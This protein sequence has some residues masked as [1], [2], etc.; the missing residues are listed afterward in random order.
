[1]GMA[2]TGAEP[3][4]WAGL[5]ALLTKRAVLIRQS[6]L[7]TLSACLVPLALFLAAFVVKQHAA[8]S[9]SDDPDA[10]L[11][12]P[13]DPAAISRTR[14]VAV[15]LGGLYESSRV[16]LTSYPDVPTEFTMSFTSLLKSHGSK[17]ERL[18]NAGGTLLDFARASFVDYTKHY[19]LGGVF[20][21][22]DLEGWYNPF[23]NLSK[24][25]AVSLLYT[26]L[27][28][29]HTGHPDAQIWTS[30]SVGRVRGPGKPLPD[31]PGKFVWEHTVRARL[32]AHLSAA[33][34][35]F[36]TPW[37]LA[38][39]MSGFVAFPVAE[40]L[41]RAKDLQLMTGVPRSVYCISNWLVDFAL[42]SLTCT[43]FVALFV[44]FEGLRMQ[45]YGV[46]EGFVDLGEHIT[47]DQMGVLADHGMV[48]MFQPFTVALVAVLLAYSWVAILFTY[49]VARFSATVAGAYSAMI[50][51]FAIAGSVVTCLYLA[52][53][54]EDVW[55]YIDLLCLAAPPW[56]LERSLVKVIR[57]DAQNQLCSDIVDRSLRNGLAYRGACPSFRPYMEALSLNTGPTISDC[58][59]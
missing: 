10:F 3:S 14:E 21:R 42:Y 49:L 31:A 39:L 47:D 53:A 40:T 24:A 12:A 1:M 46:I 57:L 18:S 15:T 17:L 13:D 5:K 4:T 41:C 26:T 25:L 51:I 59:Q 44:F 16:F 54:D 58:C 56:S 35:A 20:R 2:W 8:S 30:L 37:F 22:N 28:R 19:V 6:A 32:D 38:A 34:V 23:A 33:L 48:V 52:L 43:G 29:V 9:L 27:L 50:C 11:E 45:S 36:A 7:A 55:P